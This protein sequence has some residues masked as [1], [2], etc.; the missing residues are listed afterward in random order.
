VRAWP[1]VV[2]T[3][4]D[5]GR[6]LLA[7][8]P[9]A[10][11]AL[12]L[13]ETALLAAPEA[14]GP[15]CCLSCLRRV[16]EGSPGRCHCPSC[17][18]PFCGPECRAEVQ[19]VH[20]H[21]C[22]LMRQLR[23]R[24]APDSGG[25]AGAAVRLLCRGA[26]IRV[27]RPSV[28][29]QICRLDTVELQPSEALL[30]Q[31]VAQAAA[32]TPGL[33]SVAPRDVLHVLAAAQCNAHDCR[34]EEDSAAAPGHRGGGGGGPAHAA[35]FAL[36]S[37]LEHSCVPN[38]V[39]F[40]RLGGPH[41]GAAPVLQL[42]ALRDIRPGESLSIAYVP[43]ADPTHMRQ[44]SL[45]RRWGFRCTCTRCVDP[46]ELGSG[47]SSL[48]C[49]SCCSGWLAP[50]GGDYDRRRATWACSRC[51]C[52][53]SWEDVREMEGEMQSRISEMEACG[54]NGSGA[55]ALFLSAQRPRLH[56]N[57]WAI[58]RCNFTLATLCTGEE[59][60]DEGTRGTVRRACEEALRFCGLFGASMLECTAPVQECLALVVL[61]SP[62]PRSAS[63]R[64]AH[65]EE[66]LRLHR[67]ATA[68]YTALY[69]GQWPWRCLQRHAGLVLRCRDGGG[70]EEPAASSAS[71]PAGLPGGAGGDRRLPRPSQLLVGVDRLDGGTCV[72]RLAGPGPG[73]PGRGGPGPPPPGGAHPT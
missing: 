73:L 25:Q 67:L 19:D 29:E 46:A 22:R 55:M 17:G 63:E 8:A 40:A 10:H 20:V 45:W 7:A 34:P 24:L 54:E 14:S 38:C 21:E 42:R 68:S 57:H 32:S 70:S 28:W 12:V 56:P 11:G 50:A 26:A 6:V 62:P 41:G 51:T 59:L 60:A 36:G 16:P 13:E 33:H 44:E 65:F 23:R 47:I 71:V 35:L 15:A 61:R 52:C 69:G 2:R 30:A 9:L 49:S 72:P 43:L 58:F 3:T 64:R 31:A 1:L 4:P 48:R 18:L 27:A 66:A 37:L 53:R 5:R 39:K